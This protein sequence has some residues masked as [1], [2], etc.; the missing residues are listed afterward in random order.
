DRIYCPI[1]I[2]FSE[3][4]GYLRLKPTGRNR[5]RTFTE[6]FAAHGWLLDDLQYP[7]RGRVLPEERRGE[8]EVDAERLEEHQAAICNDYVAFAVGGVGADPTP[9][10]LT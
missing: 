6:L 2:R 4:S 1:S 9:N 7:Q 3:D 10:R 8:A 5:S